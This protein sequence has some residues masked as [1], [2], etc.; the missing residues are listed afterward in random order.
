V[1][2]RGAELDPH[3]DGVSPEVE[4]A[5]V[6]RHRADMWMLPKG[7]PHHGESAAQAALR[8]V[9]EETGVDAEFITHLGEVRYWYARGGRRV[10]KAVTFYLFR[11]R[12]GGIEDHDDEV[13]D[14]RWMPIEQAARE[15][16]YEG[17]RAI[18]ARA[19]S[20]LRADR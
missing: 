11:Y 9:R 13:E 12:A 2:R 16:T 10:P 1:F 3:R 18:V 20:R 19:L 5:L 7:T 6:G 4:I 8:E 17:E 15:L 14:A